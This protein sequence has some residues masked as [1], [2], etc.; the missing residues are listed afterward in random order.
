MSQAGLAWGGNNNKR[1]ESEVSAFNSVI[2]VPLLWFLKTIISDVM[3]LNHFLF[4]FNVFFL[5]I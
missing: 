1:C 4:D 3:L 2:Q 5:I